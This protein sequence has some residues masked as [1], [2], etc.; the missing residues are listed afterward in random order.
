MAVPSWLSVSVT[1][2]G[3]PVSVI[4]SVGVPVVVT[5]NE[6]GVPAVKLAE[7]SL[8]IAGASSTVSV[9]L[10]VAGVPVVLVDTPTP[11]PVEAQPWVAAMQRVWQRVAAE[12]AVPYARGVA[13]FA[14][15]NPALFSD[16]SHL[17][18][19]CRELYTRL[20][21]QNMPRLPDRKQGP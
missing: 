19:S 7:L 13:G 14:N 2:L 16:S 3:K 21:A 4:E 11:A 8:V 20:F 9:K 12:E 5:V 18:T 6:P 15:D 10:C 17:S 1:P